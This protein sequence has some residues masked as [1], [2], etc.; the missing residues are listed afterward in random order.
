MKSRQMLYEDNTVG[1]G[2]ILSGRK[3]HTVMLIDRDNE[4]YV[5][6]GR[7]EPIRN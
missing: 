6:S 2:K 5:T 4:S 3:E 7:D 1:K